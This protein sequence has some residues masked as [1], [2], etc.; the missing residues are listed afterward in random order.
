MKKTS[1]KLIFLIFLMLTF[2]STNLYSQSIKYKKIKK[3]K[4]T[5]NWRLEDTEGNIVKE[6]TTVDGEWRQNG[7]MLFDYLILDL[8]ENKTIKTALV[9]LGFK[10]CP[11]PFLAVQVFNEGEYFPG[12]AYRK[13]YRFTETV[14]F[15]SKHRPMMGC[16]INNIKLED[17]EASI[18]IN[19]GEKYVFYI[20]G[21]TDYKWSK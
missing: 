18:K 1:G 8:D 15:T 11:M 17:T 5:L 20:L 9:V 4:G 19:C 16:F 2:L 13:H 10:A 14:S 7:S 3:A 12:K 21:G 6:G